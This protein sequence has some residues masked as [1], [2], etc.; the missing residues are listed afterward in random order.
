[1]HSLKRIILQYTPA[2]LAAECINSPLNPVADAACVSGVD[3]AYALIV[4]TPPTYSVIGRASRDIIYQ[5]FPSHLICTG[6][7]GYA[8]PCGRRGLRR[9]RREG[10]ERG[11]EFSMMFKVYEG[12]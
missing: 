5:A 6:E 12:Y 9:Q 10:K 2:E 8:H 7:P 4:L 1:M 3:H 11:D